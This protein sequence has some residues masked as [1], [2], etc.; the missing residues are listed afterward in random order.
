METRVARSVRLP[1]A[2]KVIR[3]SNEKAAGSG[4]GATKTGLAGAKLAE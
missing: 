4:S 2:G 1:G 3:F